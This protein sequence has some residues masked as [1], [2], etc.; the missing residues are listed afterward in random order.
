MIYT[1][2]AAKETGAKH[3]CSAPLLH[4]PRQNSSIV[5]LSNAKDLLFLHVAG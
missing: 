2:L 4:Y 3:L 5:I 1:K